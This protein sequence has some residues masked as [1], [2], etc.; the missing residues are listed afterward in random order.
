[1]SHSKRRRGHHIEEY[2]DPLPGTTAVVATPTVQLLRHHELGSSTHGISARRITVKVPIQPSQQR[3]NPAPT[4]DS[5]DFLSTNFSAVDGGNDMFSNDFLDPDYE[6]EP[7]ETFDI[8]S[9]RRRT[10]AM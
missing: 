6:H 2:L 7:V 1:M 4:L 10:T 8:L 9:K 3:P 5:D